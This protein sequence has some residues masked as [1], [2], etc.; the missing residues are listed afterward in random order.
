M[1]ILLNTRAADASELTSPT[2]P[3][4]AYDWLGMMPP[5]AM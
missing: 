2:T 3:P 5:F 1:A 4:P